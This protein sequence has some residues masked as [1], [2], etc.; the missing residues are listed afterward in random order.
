LSS[1]WAAGA[2]QGELTTLLVTANF[3]PKTGGSGRWFYE[4]YRRLPR[5][6]FLV[7]AGEDPRQAEV[8]CEKN[9]RMIRLP[10]VMREWGVNSGVGSLGYVR[11]VRRLH[12]LTRHERVKMVHCGRTLP[13]GV[14]GLILKLLTGIPYACYVHGEEMETAASSREF[15]WLVRRVLA[16]ADFTIANSR[17]TE[18]ILRRNWGLSPARVRL[19]YPGVDTT[20]FVP[21]ARDP[22]VRSRLGWGCRPV[23]LTVGRLQKRKGHDH[24]IQAL[25]AIRPQVPD[26][27]Y[28]IAGDGEE[29]V[30]LE[31]LVRRGGLAQSVQFLDEP[32]DATLVTCYQQCDLFVLPNRQVGDDIEGFGMVLLEAQACGKAVVAGASGGTVETMRI[33]ETGE[34]V[35]CSTPDRLAGVVTCL[36]GDPVRRV[37]MG[38]AGRRWVV[39]HFDWA[40][41]SRQAEQ[42]FSEPPLLARGAWSRR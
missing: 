38:E 10:L 37:R 9:L 20:R 21:A 13:E 36:L 32:D 19:L 16:H 40:S 30:A 23:V 24:L 14:M 39:E 33:G 26:I 4:L 6:R 12:Q 42:L 28:A 41:L 17:N 3:P 27:L 1:D 15:T 31:A 34:L 2:R 25:S 35:D 29:R 7:A 5:E 22:S 18:G 8:D 11:A